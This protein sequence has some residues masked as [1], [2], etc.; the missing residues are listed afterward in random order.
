MSANNV[1]FNL[2]RYK[3][4]TN[5]T[6][7]SGIVDFD[8]I[9]INADAT[10]F[11]V[12]QVKAWFVDNTTDPSRPTHK[13]KVLAAQTGITVTNILTAN[14][15]FIGINVSGTV[16]QQVTSFTNAQTRTIIPLGGITHSNHTTV[17]VVNDAPVIE[18]NLG[19]QFYDLMTNIG[20][21]NVSGNL[22]ASN[23][24]SLNITKTAGSISRKGD[25][26]E[27]N[28]DDPHTITSATLNPATFGYR[29]STASF[30]GTNTTTVD[31]STYES[32]LGTNTAVTTNK[33]TI[34][35]IWL[36]PNDVVAIQ[37]GQAQ[38]TNL[39][40]AIEAL[41]NEAYVANAAL[42]SRALLR[43]F[44]VVREGATD[45]SDASQA[46]FFAA[47]R[48]AD[49]ATVSATSVSTLQNAYDNSVTPEMLTDS[50][51]G[52]LS[53]K[54]GSSAD[55][56]NVVEVLNGAGTITASVKGNGNISGGVLTLGTD[57]A[58]TE[59]GTGAS[60]AA[61][62]RTNLGLGNVDN[63]SDVN[64][65]VSTAQQTAI[66]AKVADAINNGTT[67]IAPS[68][69]A[70]FDALALKQN[71]LG[72]TAE[73][74]ANKSTSTSLG[75]SNTLYPSQNAVKVYVDTANATNANLTGPITSVGNATS[76]ASQTGTGTKFVV[77]TSP[78]LVTP[79]L[80]VAGG[81]SL[82]L[83]SAV[84]NQTLYVV[85][86]PT[87]V[88][89]A[90]IGAQVLTIPTPASAPAV[91]TSWR[92]L[93]IQALTGSANA[94]DMTNATLFGALGQATHQG[95]ATLT[96]ATGMSFSVSNTNSGTITTASNFTTLINNTSTGTITAAY[97][98]RVSSSLNSGGGAITTNCG[99]DI[100]AQTAGATN[101]GVRIAGPSGGATAN[102][103]LQLSGTAGTAATGITF[104]TDTTLYRSAANTLKTDDSVNVDL[105]LVVNEIG[106]DNDTRIEGDTDTN[107]VFVDASTD[108]VGIGTATPGTKL[109]VAGVISTK[110][111]TSTGEI[112]KVGGVLPMDNF[113]DVSVGGAEADI[114]SYTT[115]ANTFATNGDKVTASYGGNFVTVGTELT[116]LKVYFAGTAIW[117]STG[118]A[119]TTGTTSWKVSVELIRVSATVVRY[120]VTLNTTGASGFVYCT[121]GEL[122]GLTL[123]N[124]NILKITGISTG[125][126]SGAGDIVGKMSL[127]KF[128][129]AGA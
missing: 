33:F 111:G 21:F 3:R 25:N 61:D 12:G 43:G 15:S 115:P 94:Q 57:L 52:A 5:N 18:Y 80:G 7:S 38:Y 92:G 86:V 78:T 47:S 71:S 32:P 1:N 34:Q 45:L 107:L 84:T 98:L 122:T 66:D 87:S 108:R 31:P 49:A 48:F 77:D 123:S 75:T 96:T 16:I 72:Y 26:Y 104:G 50:T 93:F 37:Y 51:R 63:T 41:P 105:G 30:A 85:R 19:L 39:A 117:D 58:L 46:R 89:G 109:G 9:S 90:D 121:V 103:A 44:M 129:P 112:A 36:A 128:E 10:K 73:D 14:G 101:I 68:Q 23:G 88:S 91:G 4:L 62:A 82:G 76:I 120:T 74:V 8:G 40:A 99:V 27:T 110:A 116:Q 11:D 55:T 83:G 20:Q 95:T 114:Y 22:F 64:K 119:P 113:A 127:G 65:P 106:G 118:V 124:T 97:G 126:G 17:T 69:N 59:G 125:V 81:T 79:T 60:T 24:A 67:T 102:Y 29:N 56:D 42:L 100:L 13:Y 28:P 35:R 2:N 70:V 53:I 54:R 6:G